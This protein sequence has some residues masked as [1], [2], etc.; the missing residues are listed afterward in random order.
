M[1]RGSW[2]AWMFTSPPHHAHG[3][4]SEGPPGVRCD[5]EDRLAG[6]AA[7]MGAH[8]RS[9]GLGRDWSRYKLSEHPRRARGGPHPAGIVRFVRRAVMIVVSLCLPGP[10]L[11]EEP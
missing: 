5:E 10:E 9:D 2:H 6:A 1:G 3:R 8:V 4:R 7:T 11:Q